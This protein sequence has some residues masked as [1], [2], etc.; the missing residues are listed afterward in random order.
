M[1]SVKNSGARNRRP[2]SA[3]G[4]NLKK[5]ITGS[6]VHSFIQQIFLVNVYHMPSNSSKYLVTSVNKTNEHPFPG[7]AQIFWWGRRGEIDTNNEHDEQIR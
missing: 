4:F 2:L 7:G 3:D 5:K 6:S 1:A